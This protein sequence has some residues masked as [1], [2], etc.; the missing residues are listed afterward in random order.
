[1][2]PTAR[3][4]CARKPASQGPPLISSV[5]EPPEAK[6]WQ[7]VG[8]GHWRSTS[9]GARA[10]R[11]PCAA[12]VPWSEVA[13]RVT[14][15]LH[16]LTVIDDI[17]PLR[18]GLKEAAACMRI[19]GSK[20]IHTDIYTSHSEEIVGD[21]LQR[22]QPEGSGRAFAVPPASR[23]STI[24]IYRHQKISAANRQLVSEVSIGFS[25]NR[26]FKV[27]F[28]TLVLAMDPTDTDTPGLLHV[29]NTLFPLSR[30]RLN[31]FKRRRCGTHSDVFC[32][33]KSAIAHN[34]NN[35]NLG[36]LRNSRCTCT[37]PCQACDFQS[38]LRG[39]PRARPLSDR[40]A[41]S[42]HSR[43][44]TDVEHR[45]PLH[46]RRRDS[47]HTRSK[48][49]DESGQCISLQ[50]DQVNAKQRLPSPLPPLD[51]VVRAG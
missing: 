50:L 44:A 21:A 9:K 6:Q 48:C 31:L 43:E 42:M 17:Y 37:I 25:S 10:Y 13:R 47:P 45:P 5:G 51:C 46:P 19:G 34:D 27:A 36:L 41:V 2:K 16:T 40:H 23:Q 3:L 30:S 7:C 15:E 39:R 22:P 38:S 4:H 35:S 8:T 49:A 26:A 14:S 28:D 1:M 12:G 18:D 32:L 29:E 11:S 24:N 33:G 20:D